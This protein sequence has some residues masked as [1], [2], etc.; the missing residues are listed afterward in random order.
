MIQRGYGS[1]FAIESLTEAPGGNLDRHVAPSART[2]RAENIA[3]AAFADRCKYFV[4]DGACRPP[5]KTPSK[6][7]ARSFASTGAPPKTPK[8]TA[9]IRLTSSRRQTLEELQASDIDR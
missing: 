3:Y 2:M 9:A 7:V 1:N 6:T 4:K 5:V 8:S